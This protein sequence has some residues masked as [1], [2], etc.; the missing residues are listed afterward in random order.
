MI[1]INLWSHSTHLCHSPTVLG[2]APEAHHVRLVPLIAWGSA[3]LLLLLLMVLEVEL[4]RVVVLHE[5][6]RH[7]V[8]LEVLFTHCE[9]SFF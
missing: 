3:H 4:V 7:S 9:N 8:A 1:I 5:W 2:R 6:A